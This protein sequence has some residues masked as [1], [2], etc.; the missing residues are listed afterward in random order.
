MNIYKKG[1]YIE[2]LNEAENI[3]QR[4]RSI[5]IRFEKD[6]QS[7]EIYKV[8]YND[9]LF[10][11][12]PFAEI[13]D[14]TNT[15][16][17]SQSIFDAWH[18]ANTGFNPATGGSVAD[19]L[20]YVTNKTDLPLAVNGVITLAANATYFFTKTVD[21]TGDRLVCGANTTILGFSSENCKIISTGLSAS[22]ALISSNYSLPIRN[23]AFTSGTVLNLVGD[24][25]TTALDWHGVNFVDCPTV[26]LIK[27][28]TNFIMG[29]SAFLNSA[30]LTLDGTI[31]TIGFSNSLFDGRT[32]GQTTIIIAA[33]ANITRRFRIIYS[34]FVCLSG[35]TAIN[36][37][38]SATIADER[39]ILDTVNFAG[40]G[41]YLTG[42]TETSNKALYSAC[43][44]ITNTAVN[45]QLYMQ[46]N[47]TATVIS[48]ANTFYKALGTTTAS[49]DN[50]KYIM[51]NNRL[52]NAANVSRK[53]LIQCILSFTSGNNHVCEFG[54]YD[55]K[56]GAIRT[57]SRTKST[58]NSG[59]RAE[60]V[61]FACVVSH[62]NG[63]F[64][65]I[66]AA[67]NTSA[68][69][70]TITDMNFLITEIK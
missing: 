31:G 63:D 60:N 21:L 69:N 5:D 59:G 32:S 24:S 10:L 30:N 15:A 8:F 42:V 4:R 34:S 43:V 35:E 29:D 38:A 55:S 48:A 41:T 40:G 62:S 66:H 27:D 14:E 37:S 46:S 13:E 57:P 39:Y 22:T 64:I 53:Y 44:G 19:V 11:M 50:S 20:V 17:A 58:S 3:L 2:F 28:Y 18:T 16:Y 26:G 67:N 1:N 65:E 23:I 51:T 25:V 33:T 6:S 9:V 49:D 68:Q 12:I 7:T 52:T 56:L 47:A 61:S 54:F 36:F 70:I 45:G